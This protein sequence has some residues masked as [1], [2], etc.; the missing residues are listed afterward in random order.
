MKNIKRNMRYTVNIGLMMV[1]IFMSISIGQAAIS[2]DRTIDNNV[3]AAGSSTNVTVVIHNDV[4]QALSLQ[5]II[6]SGFILTRISDDADSFRPNEWIWM[7][8][9]NDVAKTVKYMITVPQNTVAGAY[10]IKGN[11][12]T[13]GNTTSVAGDSTITVTGQMSTSSGSSSGTYPTITTTPGNAT[14]AI[15]PIETTVSP[16]TIAQSAI[17]AVEPT[18]Q[19][20]TAM[21]VTTK[22]QAPGFE[23]IAAIGI[24]G[25]IYLLRKMK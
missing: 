23:I 4:T 20:D 11:I 1:L 8:V 2:A 24:F 12:M 19:S 3:L 6:P 9:A 7:S 13:N 25:S 14:N 16:T 21:P 10:N 5:E 18:A 22:Q 17:T 15:M